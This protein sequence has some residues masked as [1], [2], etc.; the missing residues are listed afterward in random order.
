MCSL[1]KQTVP[2]QFSQINFYSSKETQ[3]GSL[4]I[5]EMIIVFGTICS[6]SKSSKTKIKPNIMVS[7]PML[8][9]AL[10]KKIQAGILKMKPFVLITIALKTLKIKLKIKLKISRLNYLTCLTK[11]PKY[12]MSRKRK[13]KN[14][15]RKKLRKSGRNYQEK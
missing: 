15:E 12:K 7:R 5:T 4:I 6:T 3:K 11:F 2:F 9:T 10:I 13:L 14:K 8:I 1:D